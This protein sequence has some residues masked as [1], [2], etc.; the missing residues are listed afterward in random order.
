MSGSTRVSKKTLIKCLQTK[1]PTS[2]VQS[3]AK[4]IASHSVRYSSTFTNE[5]KFEFFSLFSKIYYKTS[6][7]FI[8]TLDYLFLNQ[9]FCLRSEF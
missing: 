6:P 4:D 9:L 5:M 8:F 1:Q 3:A 7:G 2:F